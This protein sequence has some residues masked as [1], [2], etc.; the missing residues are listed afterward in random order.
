METH[1]IDFHQL[2]PHLNFCNDIER[3]I[4]I[5]KN[6]FI[7][8]LCSTDEIFP[9]NLWDKLIPQCLITLNLLRGSCI[10]TKL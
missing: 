7:A 6:H 3:A 4:C 5:F 1:E 8:G 9:P 10:N 2:P